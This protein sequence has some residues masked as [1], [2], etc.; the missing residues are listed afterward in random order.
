MT[1]KEELQKAADKC[2]KVLKEQY[3]VK[4]VFIIGSLVKGLIHKY[5]DIDLVV[6]GLPI[7]LYMKVLTELWELLP[8]GVELNL[9]PFEGAFESLKKK[10]IQEGQLV[11]G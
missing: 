2:I 10:T 3:N 7:E 9:I 5:S 4:R 6:E 11:Y 8:H 1:K